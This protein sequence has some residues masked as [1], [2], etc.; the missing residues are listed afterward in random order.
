MQPILIVY[1]TREGHTRHVAEHLGSVLAANQHPSEIVDAA[2][3]PEG[4]SLRNY[5]AA[6]LA[7]SL[8]MFKYEREMT[9]F[10][11]RRLAQLQPMFTVFLSVSLAERSIEDPASSPEHR[12]EAQ[13]GLQQTVDRFLTET[14]WHPSR[15]AFAAGAL[16]YSKYDF[17]TR[18]IMKRIS[19]HEGGPVDTSRDYEFTDWAKLHQ[20]VEELIQVTEA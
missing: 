2:H 12:A 8:H 16:M 15:I 1:A 4:F 17:V 11:K 18:F 13:K 6:I 7:A 19:K 10:V 14:G 20:L 5:S 9:Q 3:L